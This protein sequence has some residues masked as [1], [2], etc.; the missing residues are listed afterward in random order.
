MSNL[1]NCINK[2]FSKPKGRFKYTLGGEGEILA[3][4]RRTVR[5]YIGSR[6]SGEMS[7]SE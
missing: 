1:T 6:G 4:S 3:E 7:L 2:M 5:T